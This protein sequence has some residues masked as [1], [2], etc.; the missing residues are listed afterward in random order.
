MAEQHQKAQ[1]H[2]R[3]KGQHYGYENYKH[4]YEHDYHDPY[5]YYDPYA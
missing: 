2:G 5:A 1:A 3:R 4:I